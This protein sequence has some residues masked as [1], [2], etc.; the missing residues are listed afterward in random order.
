[1]GAELSK[2]Q[3]TAAATIQEVCGNEANTSLSSQ[4]NNSPVNEAKIEQ[5]IE[6]TKHSQKTKSNADP[7]RANARLQS[8]TTNQ[9]ADNLN[10]Q[11]FSHL[12]PGCAD[13]PQGFSATSIPNVS[14]KQEPVLANTQQNSS[15][16]KNQQMAPD[17]SHILTSGSETVPSS[18]SL[19]EHRELVQRLRAESSRQN[20]DAQLEME[21]RFAGVEDDRDAVFLASENEAGE[22]EKRNKD[23]LKDTQSSPYQ[24]VVDGST[25]RQSVEDD[26]ED[27]GDEEDDN[28]DEDKDDGDDDDEDE[29]DDD[30][31]DEDDDDEDASENKASNCVER[32]DDDDEGAEA[33]TPPRTKN[34]L[35]DEDLPI[36]PFDQVPAE[37]LPL[38]QRIGVVHSIVG[39]VVL[40]AQETAPIKSDFGANNRY[41][42]L[43]SESL[44]CF[45]NGQV[46]GVVY[47]TFGS[48]LAP[49][50]SVR[51]KNET[52]VSSVVEIGKP[53]FYLPTNSTF[54][55]ARQIRNKGSDASNMWDEEV[56]AEEV[57]YSD[58]EEEAAAKRQ[59]KLARRLGGEVDDLKNFEPVDPET[60]SLGPLGGFGPERR[61]TTGYS[62]RK[63][64]DD[65][66]GSDAWTKRQR[67][68]RAGTSAPHI[69]PRFAGQWLRPGSGM[70]FPLPMPM[71]PYPM[72]STFPPGF[73]IAHLSEFHEPY[74]PYDPSLGQRPPPP[75]RQ[76]PP[77]R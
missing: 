3:R 29:E 7:P 38:I 25:N 35:E 47:E 46:L 28:E 42:V 39:N 77:Y 54:V 48:V 70:Q 65:R 44:L 30:D 6:T 9:N 41:D 76:D 45:E 19:E 12:E 63:R 16:A 2:L 40:V 56:A 32:A 5:N 57:E 60:A 24:N 17:L 36:P 18:G 67:P 14:S 58:D 69:N 43:D 49:M 55:L 23:E 73:S 53:V 26:D 75:R 20:S 33:T 71:S 37:Q 68:S 50:Y 1:M 31:E 62:T 66:R 13:V 61:G 51:F 27:E 22:L 4:E 8:Q 72:P 15:S 52:D 64:R 11:N 10:E 74:Q 34:E 59:T 21:M